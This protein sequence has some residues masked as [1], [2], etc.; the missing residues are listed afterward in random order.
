MGLFQSQK[1]YKL[2]DLGISKLITNQM[3]NN[4]GTSYYIA[5][6]N[7]QGNQ[8]DEK[9]D[10]WAFGCVLYNLLKAESLS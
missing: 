5:P 4:V 8:Y 9:V 1:V 2:I 3:T 6:E 10:I 7:K